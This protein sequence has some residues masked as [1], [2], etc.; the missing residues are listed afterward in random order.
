MGNEGKHSVPTSLVNYFLHELLHYCSRYIHWIHSNSIK[1]SQH[2]DL[3]AS[4]SRQDSKV[5]SLL[6]RLPREILAETAA[7]LDSKA[8]LNF[9]LLNT[10]ISTAIEHVVIRRFFRHRSVII[11]VDSLNILRQVS[12][13]EKY[14]AKVISLNV[15]S[16]HVAEARS[17]LELECLNSQARSMIKSNHAH[18]TMLLRNQEWLM[19]SGQAAAHLA[20]ALKSLPNCVTVNI[21]KIRNNLESEIR[22][23]EKNPLLT[24]SMRLP[25]SL[26]FVKRLISTTMTA[27]DASGCKLETLRIGHANGDIGIQQ[28]PRLFSAQFGL[29]FSNLSSLSLI[30][31]PK[32]SDTQDD[33]KACL[34]DW[35]KSL[36]SLKCLELSFWPRLRRARFSS[37]G[38]GLSVDGLTTFVLRG[39]DCHYDDLAVLLKRH[40]DT[41]RNITLYC[42]D[43]TGY[44]EPWRL[45]LELIRYETMID[46]MNCLCCTSDERE[47]S[48]GA[49]FKK[50]EMSISHRKSQ[51]Q[52]RAWCC[53]ALVNTFLETSF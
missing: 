9:R 49:H 24:T 5:M 23:C 26:D 32:Y 1:I 41:L 7:F 36:S 22:T 17:D 47:I 8:L 19:E 15:C 40:R 33:W 18:Y 29:P 34:F 25:K 52:G 6:E 10:N 46:S 43:L 48:F 44:D 2:Q 21:R 53:Y 31:G 11:N 16:H 42:V 27:I 45:V 39:V 35:T 14:R 4:R 20:L 51:V 50:G 3:T 12:S 13:S 37:I 38:R 28:L 30:L